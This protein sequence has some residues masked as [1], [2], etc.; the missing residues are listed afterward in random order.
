MAT[1]QRIYLVTIGESD[2][3]VK[4]SHP[5]AALM[6]VARHIASVRV[7]TQTDLIDCLTDGVEVED[8]AP[9]VAEKSTPTPLDHAEEL[10]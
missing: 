5:A 10:A 4:A 3:L 9:L 8:A 1:Q 7:A 2:R 6:H